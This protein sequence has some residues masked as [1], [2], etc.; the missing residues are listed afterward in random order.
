[1]TN[2]KY[3]GDIVAITTKL[4]CSSLAQV[5]FPLWTNSLPIET[6]QTGAKANFKKIR[7]E[8]TVFLCLTG[9][10][11]V[12]HVSRGKKLQNDQINF[13]LKVVQ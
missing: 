8:I 10:C 12:K 2:L 13:Y 3:R 9:T 4:N 1:M 7:C 5:T 6:I 11:L